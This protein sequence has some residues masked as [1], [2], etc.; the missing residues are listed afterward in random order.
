MGFGNY[1]QCYIRNYA[2]IASP[3]NDLTKKGVPWQWGPYQHRAFHNLKEAYCSAPILIFP[4]PKLPYTVIN[5]ASWT[6]GGG[7]LMQDQGEGLQPLAF[8]N[9]RLK[10]IEQRYLAYEQELAVVAYCLQSW[11]HYLEGCPGGVTVITD[12][13]PLICFMDQP[14]LTRVQTR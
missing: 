12:H 8:L 10:P 6:A 2:D 14:L 5:D 11:R 3:L 9:R 13:Q 1:Y 7:S 4:D